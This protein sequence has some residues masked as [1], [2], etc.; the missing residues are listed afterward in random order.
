M[1]IWMGKTVNR[2]SGLSG[3]KGT[4]VNAPMAMSGAVSPIARL[5][6]SRMSLGH[7]LRRDYQTA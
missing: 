1:N 5:T 6:A 7:W 4:K 2:L 3:V